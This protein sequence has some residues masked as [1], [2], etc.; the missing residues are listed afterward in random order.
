MGYLDLL[1]SHYLASSPICHLETIAT[2]GVAEITLLVF[3]GV[4]ARHPPL[5]SHVGSIAK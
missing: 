5:G 4:G 1:I 2:R 3:A